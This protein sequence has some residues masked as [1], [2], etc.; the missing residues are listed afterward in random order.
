MAKKASTGGVSANRI[1]NDPVFERTRENMGEVTINIP[2]FVPR[3]SVE[4]AKGA[5]HIRIVAAVA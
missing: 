1:K 4:Q 5:T 3:Q 2:S